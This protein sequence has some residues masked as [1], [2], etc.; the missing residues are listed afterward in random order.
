MGSPNKDLLRERIVGVDWHR[1]VREA[2]EETVRRWAKLLVVGTLPQYAGF[3]GAAEN[4]AGAALAAVQPLQE[5]AAAHDLAIIVVRHE[6]KS[7]G[8]V[9][10][11]R[12][13]SSAFAGAVIVSI[14]RPEANSRPE[15]RELPA[16]SGFDD[17]PDLLIVELTREGCRSLGTRVDVAAA[18]AREAILDALPADEAGAMSLDELLQNTGAMGVRV[19]SKVSNSWTPGAERK[20]NIS[21][22]RT[23]VASPSPC[24]QLIYRKCRIPEVLDPLGG[25]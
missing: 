1:I 13:G 6:R 9:G 7:G 5:A 25:G 23:P 4:S 12:R 20:G 14:R 10:D 11:S 2:V 22:A 21:V 3:R 16:L 17:T 15:I 19:G 8:H 24:R 18:E